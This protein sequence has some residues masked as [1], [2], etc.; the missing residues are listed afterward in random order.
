MSASLAGLRTKKRA[1][2]KIM[3]SFFCL[4]C[5]LPTKP[6]IASS[7]ATAAKSE[8]YAKSRSVAV[9]ITTVTTVTIPVWPIIATIVWPAVL[10]RWSRIPNST[11]TSRTWFL[12]GRIPIYRSCS[13]WTRFAYFCTFT[14]CS[15]FARKNIIN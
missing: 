12:T 6:E 13:Y 2:V 10:A 7:K 14:S 9:T 11:I 4:Q 3:H 8:A 15:F 1:H 5:S